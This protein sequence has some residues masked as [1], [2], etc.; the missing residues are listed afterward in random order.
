MDT[1]EKVARALHAHWQENYRGMA[2]NDPR[3]WEELDPFQREFG[4]GA[5]RAAVEACLTDVAEEIARWPTD[6][7]NCSHVVQLLRV[8]AKQPEMTFPLEWKEVDNGYD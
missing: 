6:M 2:K 1:L 7:N 8:M 4:I 5:A 3:P